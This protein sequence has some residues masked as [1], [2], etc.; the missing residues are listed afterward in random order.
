MNAETA[1]REWQD[2][3]WFLAARR[4][5]WPMLQS[6]PLL[7]GLVVL[8][9]GLVTCGA[10]ETMADDTSIFPKINYS[11]NRQLCDAVLKAA[12]DSFKEDGNLCSIPIFTT[13]DGVSSLKWQPE[14][15]DGN[16]NLLEQNLPF[17]G[18]DTR[19]STGVVGRAD[20]MPIGEIKKEFWNRFGSEM[21]LALKSNGGSFE[22]VVVDV[23]NDGVVEKV[24]R[25]SVLKPFSSAD[26]ER[27]WTISSCAASNAEGQ[28]YYGIFFDPEVAARMG[29]LARFDAADTVNLMRFGNKTFRVLMGPR[30]ISISKI[31]QLKSGKEAYFDQQC[32]IDTPPSE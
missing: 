4:S 29:T 31:S 12:I 17:L 18:W 27:G 2:S 16:E 7:S 22:S 21:K 13:G 6:L 3:I 9:A 30:L 10:V 28:P 14:D 32:V 8:A 25:V 20:E 23:D 26:P 11:A 5:V 19:L 24:Y 15:I 1:V